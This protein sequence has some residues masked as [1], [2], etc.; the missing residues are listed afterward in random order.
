MEHQQTIRK[1]V[2]F[3]GRALQT[4]RKTSVRCR[5]AGEDEGINFI[6]VDAPGK[7]SLRVGPELL[8]AEHRRR[9]TLGMGKVQVQTVEHFLAALWGLG[10]DNILVEIDGVELPALDGSAL[11]FMR[12]LKKA[13]VSQ[14]A[15][16][17]RQVFIS[18][19]LELE[20]DGGRIAAYPGEGLEVSYSIDYPVACIKNGK[21]TLT[22]D[23]KK[24]EQEIA[25]ARTFC[26]FSRAL[27]LF[28]SGLGRGANFRNTLVL[29]NRGP[30]GTQFRFPD[31]PVRHKVLD[32]VGDLY[33]L[34]RRVNGKIIAEKSGHTLNAKLVREIARR[35]GNEIKI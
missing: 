15:K 8:S 18:E 26:L 19:P 17:R 30:F 20:A 10:I 4:G 21:F 31:E 35:Y 13:G 23:G 33:M 11:G 24:F 7:P 12:E 6:R 32:I 29:G 27:L 25:P 9:T 2:T 22:L 1:E 28:I 5:P 16:E 3:S 34:G 14:Q